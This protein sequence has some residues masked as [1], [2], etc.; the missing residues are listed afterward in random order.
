MIMKKFVNI[1]FQI[2]ISISDNTKVSQRVSNNHNVPDNMTI[3]DLKGFLSAYD[4]RNCWIVT[5]M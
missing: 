1:C 5:K 4:K 2:M 3:H